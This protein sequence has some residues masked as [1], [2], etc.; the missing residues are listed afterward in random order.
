MTRRPRGIP[1]EELVREFFLATERLPRDTAAELAGV[2]LGTLNR[3]ERSAPRQVKLAVRTRLLDYLEREDRIAPGGE[4]AAER[5]I[6]LL[7]GAGEGVR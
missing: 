6:P 4:S 7:A 2:C 5:R 3:W 1:T